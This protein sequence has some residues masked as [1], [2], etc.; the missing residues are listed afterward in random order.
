MK[1]GSVAC[2]AHMP[3]NDKG[4]I[5]P[6]AAISS[7]V[8]TPNESKAFIRNLYENYKMILGR[9]GFMMLTVSS[10]NGQQNGI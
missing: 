1:M 3:S 9:E 8:Y 2:D 7:I 4:V 5:S 10:I 6:T